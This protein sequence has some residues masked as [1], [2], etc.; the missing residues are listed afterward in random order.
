[1]HIPYEAQIL[2]VPR[3]LTYC[4][5]PF[6]Y[7]LEDAALYTR[8]MHW[9]AFGET[10]DKLIEKFLCAD[11]EMERISAILNADIEELWTR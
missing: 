4:L 8:R 1:V 5:P 10:A 6:F 11:L 9:R 7:K 2:L 3:R